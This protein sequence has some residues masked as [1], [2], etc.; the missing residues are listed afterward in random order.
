MNK[1][2]R[3]I[4]SKTKEK[5]IVVDEK[6]AAKSGCPAATI[7]AL[8][9]AT[10]LASGGAAF[11]LDPG[12]LPTGGQI[13][14]G[15]GSIGASG[16]Q[17]TV[18]QTSQQMIANWNS[19][20]IG[21]NAGVQF[22]QPNSAATALNRIND[23]NPSQI[24]GS[25]SAN[26]KVFLLNPAGIIFGQSARVDVGGLVGSSLNMLDSDFLAG[27]YRFTNPG[28]AGS[29]LNQGIINAMPGG[30]V[31]LI[32]PKVTNEGTIATPSGSTLLAAGNQVSLDFTG[33]GLISYT[34]DQG[35]VDALAEN[36]GLIKADGGLVV[37]TAK[38]ADNLTQAVVNNS[39]VIEAQTLES[40]DGRIL[41]DGTDGMTTSSGTL[42]A[43]G[44]Q[45]GEHGGTVTLLG[46]KVGL[47]SGARLDVS[48][49]SGGGTALIGGNWQGKGVEA[50]AE[51]TYVAETAHIDASA[52]GNGDGGKVVV[53][54][55]NVTRYYG[56]IAAHG[57]AAGGNGGQ[58]EVSGKK[59]L[60]FNGRVDTTA[61]QGMGGQGGVLLLD[62]TNII[63][64]TADPLGGAVSR[65]AAADLDA[66]ADNAAETSWITPTALVT[67]LN[68]AAVTLKAY[69]DITVSSAVD[70]SLNIGNFGL[71]LDAGRSILI[72]DSIKLRGAFLAYANSNSGGG[73]SRGAGAGDFTM[74][75]GTT[76]DTSSR[77]Q[78]IT[79]GVWTQNPLGTATIKG[80]T[81]GTA[82]IAV[83][84]DSI[85][86]SGG[87][88]SISGTAYMTLMP[89]SN[90]RPGVIGAAGGAGDFAID[91]T[92]LAA[93]KDGFSYIFLG[94]GSST[95]AF[96][97]SGSPSF[98]D[99]VD[100]LAGGGITLDASAAINTNG[101]GVRFY[102]GSG[103]GGIFTQTAGATISAGGITIY[104]DVLG[105]NGAANSISGSSY[106]LAPQTASRNINIGVGAVD[107]PGVFALNTAELDTLANGSGITIGLTSGTGIAT[108]YGPLSFNVP[109]QINNY[110]VGGRITL[111][112][113]AAINTNGNSI[114]FYAGSGDIG[115]FTQS[116][117]ATLSAGAGAVKIS[118]DVI[119]LNGAAD[120]ISG[121][122]T[123]SLYPKTA[124]R[125]MSIGADAGAGVFALNT[126]ELNTLKDGFSLITLGSSGV[127]GVAILSGALSFN[128]PVNIYS[129]GAGGWITL[130]AS[131]AI[132]TNG[133]SIKFYTCTGDS[134]AFTQS[135]GATLTAGAGAVTISSDVVTL[136]GA[137]DSISGSSTI[138]LYPT[139]AARAMDLGTKDATKFTLNAAELLTLKDGFSTIEIGRNVMTGGLTLSAALRFNDSLT[140][141]LHNTSSLTVNA[142]PTVS[143]AVQFFGAPVALNA[144]VISSSGV[145]FAPGVTV[146]VDGLSVDA[147]TGTATFGTLTHNANNFT[148]TADDVTLSN[149]W[150]GTGTR[151]LQPTTTTR[152]ISLGNTSAGYLSLNNSELSNLKNGSPASVTIGRA[153]GTGSITGAFS[154]DDPL[155][156]RGGAITQ[157]GAWTLANT[158]S[159][160]SGNNDITLTQA[161]NDF[162]GLVTVVSGKNVT[163]VDA[164]ALTLGAVTATGLIDIANKTGNL[165]LT[166]AIT[167]SD[168]TANAI[169]LNADRDAAAGTAAGGNIIISG[170]TV[171]P[172]A[173]GIATLYSGSVADS[174]GL[175][176]LLVSGSG[177]FRYNSDEA[178]SNYTDALLAGS[179]AVYREKPTLT[180]KPNALDITYGDATPFAT[181]LGAYVNGDSTA[182]TI[183]GTSTWTIGGDISTG[184]KPV[185]GT[186]EATY[187][188]GLVSS[189]GYGFTDNVSSSNELTV[190]A[191]NLSVTY[192][193]VSKNYDGGIAATVTTSDDRVAGDLLTINRTASFADKNAGPG[194]TIN[195]TGVSMGNSDAGNYTVSATGSTTA[196]ITP[197]ALAVT[198]SDA[199]K[200][201]GQLATLTDFTSSGLQNGE[202]IGSVTLSSAGVAA[203]ANVAGSP[204]D[205][206]ASNATGGTFASG[207]YTITYHNG[208]LT[209]TPAAGEGILQTVP[210]QLPL[211]QPQLTD[212]SITT[213]SVTPPPTLITVPSS[214]LTIGS[215]QT[216]STDGAAQGETTT[217]NA[218]AGGN[219]GGNNAVIITPSTGIIIQLVSQASSTNTGSIMV[220]VPKVLTRPGSSFSF[221]LPE[222]VS[223]AA[224]RDG[225]VKVSLANGNPL[226]AWL[227][228]M[229]ASRTF[230]A[231]DVPAG[232]MPITVLVS[233][234]S[235]VW[236]V[237]I[238]EYINL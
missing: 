42:D 66:F 99:R 190:N 163:L 110:G 133:N 126:A 225:E 40:K 16:S 179:N 31:A 182:D 43:S 140:L 186:H 124:A 218:T 181:T 237:E 47:F 12:A 148:V 138:T 183:S 156:L 85:D 62:P 123:I 20:N 231:N 171:N 174:T 39:G 122:S 52:T 45:A 116:N 202:T 104:G 11:A 1:I 108:L 236:T 136:N 196:D 107:A 32:A 162:G 167:T 87:D 134:G 75:A 128:D 233:V 94:S 177:R 10:L 228:Y 216:D 227:R 127:T 54:A 180:V 226:P 13:T 76:I 24:L 34:I 217:G 26:G 56:T 155:I 65:S 109:V 49:D 132:N 9:V 103:D 46:N 130:D 21:A 232:S 70:A 145:S 25:L 209:V 191:K 229:H 91:T 187:N 160:Q 213:A 89:R 57:G 154:F 28:S 175:T 208:S 118:A 211:P 30:V 222:H 38:A 5:W 4:W 44:Q 223:S 112:A 142:T 146:A 135:N 48:G 178:A 106:L 59:H 170:G 188:T 199:S 74:A 197:A 51:R 129:N 93:L 189:L 15:S 63:V 86:L 161:G 18:N 84:A 29:I 205:I 173:G 68:T 80:L 220:G 172:G 58:V 88:N 119:T 184:G 195:V 90:S 143:G 192:T 50:N 96:T 67:L 198:A 23:Q 144:S 230:V 100:I 105:L 61:A 200:T 215:G 81:S 73:V 206:T 224:E 193:G 3:I 131:A 159:L 219:A 98:K 114:E 101:N 2:F 6:A 164:N 150:I 35:A 168:A 33:D 77:N 22:N 210:V 72:N 71:T 235:M 221:P 125:A 152:M 137:A 203:T 147:G 165:T 212:G 117:G 214:T 141:R 69:N 194:K 8:T 79:I 120:S 111:D 151:T 169:I 158:L 83:I 102:A 201:Y 113:S 121:S 92:E 14:S 37:M 53:W 176:A 115:A 207:N 55:D 185:V 17:M 234:G 97:I 41:L 204:Y 153:D 60:D 36:K 166:G 157:L 27:R 78:T 238:A 19:F 95:S 7:G 139:T 64:A 82:N 149:I